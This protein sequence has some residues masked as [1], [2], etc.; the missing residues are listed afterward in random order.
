MQLYDNTINGSVEQVK[1][2]E[3]PEGPPEGLTTEETLTKAAEIF[4]E[5]FEEAETVRHEEAFASYYI[6]EFDTT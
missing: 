4:F 5:M 6:Y 3:M 1:L 2:E